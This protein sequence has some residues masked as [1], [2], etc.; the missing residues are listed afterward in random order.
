MK[1]EYQSITKNGFWEIIPRP[2]DKLV[3]SS[4][5]L[6]NIKHETIGSIDKYKVRFVDR[7]FSQLEGNDYEETFSPTIRYTTIH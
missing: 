7:G 3:L 2:E 4:K 1:E 6:Y 5:W